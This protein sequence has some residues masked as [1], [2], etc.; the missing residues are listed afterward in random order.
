MLIVDDLPNIT[1]LI[2]EYETF[3]N[4]PHDDIMDTI[5]DAVEMAYMSDAIDYSALL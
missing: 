3:P 1:E 4:A 5:M 2:S